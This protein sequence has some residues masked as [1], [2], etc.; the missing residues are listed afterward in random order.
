[1]CFAS[2]VL[3]Q[4]AAS[5]LSVQPPQ[6]TALV[7]RYDKDLAAIQAEYDAIATRDTEAVLKNL[8]AMQQQLAKNP[9][10]ADAELIGDYLQ[11]YTPQRTR[12]FGGKGDETLPG[13]ALKLVLEY[14]EAGDVAFAESIK[15]R[16]ELNRRFSDWLRELRDDF[17]EARD[18]TAADAV[19]QY[20]QSREQKFSAETSSIVLKEM[21]RDL[22]ISLNAAR[23]ETR[24][25]AR[26]LFVDLRE[27]QS[28]YEKLEDLDTAL[29]IRK[30]LRD[31]LAKESESALLSSLRDEIPEIPSDAQRLIDEFLATNNAMESKVADELKKT[32]AKFISRFE[33]EVVSA[34]ENDDLDAAYARLTKFQ[35]L[36]QTAGLSID[37]DPFKWDRKTSGIDTLPM[38]DASRILVTEFLDA[39]QKRFDESDAAEQVLR[40]E[41]TLSL[42]QTLLREDLLPKDQKALKKTIR[43]LYADYTAGLRGLQL[44]QVSEDLPREALMAVKQ[45]VEKTAELRNDLAARHNS[46]FQELTQKQKA[47][48]VELIQ[49]KDYVNAFGAMA[50]VE[51]LKPLFDP[52]LVL[53]DKESNLLKAR[54]A[55]VLDVQDGKVLVRFNGLTE[56]EW[57]PRSTVFYAPEDFPAIRPEEIEIPRSLTS[58]TPVTPNLQLRPGQQVLAASGPFWTEARI[59]EVSPFGIKVHWDPTNG[60]RADSFVHRVQLLI[61]GDANSETTTQELGIVI[62]GLLGG[63]G[64]S[65]FRKVS[66]DNKP[67]TALK[68]TTGE[69]AGA[70]CINEFEPVWDQSLQNDANT[71]VARDG[72][73]LG[74]VHV[75]AKKFV[76]ALRFEFMRVAE[77]GQLN[78]EDSYLSDWFGTRGQAE[79][80]IL[81]GN[82]RPVIGFFGRR[83]AVLD[84]IGAEFGSVPEE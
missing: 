67:V 58:G 68:I 42:E 10:W 53:A 7:Q 61:P 52:I 31:L 48:R 30:L 28:H 82:G 39:R 43:F 50:C 69:W 80:K 25:G 21:N 49:Q 64:G 34:M 19:V 44:F 23:K 37:G 24:S 75:E 1:M 57:C 60:N 35:S 56:A 79:E 81:T 33:A 63:T 70:K 9:T 47:V 78:P 65:K 72:Y 14:H 2:F 16:Y 4:I 83:L 46:A 55:E 13:P 11:R 3:T 12:S 45:F 59:V 71:V 26:K 6:L 27:V 62:P 73:A 51:L 77:G 38:T 5:L 74:A 29:E 36:R 32:L 84:A 76:Y 18:A 41:L 40:D 66:P 54:M 20:L 15:R 22:N 17:R 8:R